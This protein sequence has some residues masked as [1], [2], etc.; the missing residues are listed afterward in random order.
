MHSQPGL[1]TMISV[2]PPSGTVGDT[3]VAQGENL[4]R[5]QVT[6]VYLTDGQNDFKMMIEG[7]TATSIKFKVPSGTK[8]GRFVLMVLTA[9]PN[10]RYVEEPVKITLEAEAN[11]GER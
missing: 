6:A 10:V 5:L 9:R 3:F 7:Q 1:P 11:R 2:Q 4:D 8:I